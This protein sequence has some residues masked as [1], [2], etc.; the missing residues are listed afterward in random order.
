MPTSI[1]TA[2]GLTN[3]LLTSRGRPTAAISTSARAHTS[4]RSRVR[5]WH[6]HRRVLG[7]QQLSHRLA[8]Q[9][10]APDH[11]RLGALK[12]RVDARQQLHHPRG[13]AGTQPGQPECEQP[14][15]DRGQAIDILLGS[16]TAVSA[17][18]SRWSGNGSCSSTPLTA[19]SVFRLWSSWRPGRRC[20]RRAGVCQT[21]PCPLPHR[22]AACRPRT[23]PKLGSRQPARSQVQGD[24]RLLDEL[25]HLVCHFLPHAGGDCLPVDDRGGHGVGL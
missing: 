23:Q 16:I 18:P 25:L 8:E 9:V 3:S 2:P 24:D 6:R 14:R 11:D 22:R 1:T 17:A 7:E 13:S 5:E 21:G 15:V 19:G 4:A 12:L 10:R 20:C